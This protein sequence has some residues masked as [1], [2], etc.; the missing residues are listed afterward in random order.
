MNEWINLKIDKLPEDILTGDYEVQYKAN[1]Y[2]W[3]KTNAQPYEII[4]FMCRFHI[5]YRY[6][7]PEP[8]PPT[9]EEIMTKW[10]RCEESNDIVWKNVILYRAES[11]VQE[12]EDLCYYCGC[13]RRKDWFIGRESSVLPP[14]SGGE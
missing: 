13:Y 5:E 8:L 12:G 6:R 10:W 14:E 9:H 2:R 11:S 4:S 3:T 7:T 1:K